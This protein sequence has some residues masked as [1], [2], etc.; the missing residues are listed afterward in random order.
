M[1][2]INRPN[3]EIEIPAT[4]LRL[5]S[6]FKLTYPKIKPSKLVTPPQR[7][8]IAAHK[9]TNPNAGEAIAKNLAFRNS[10]SRLLGS[11]S[12]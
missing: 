9:L 6:V 1:I 8:I 12:I 5:C 7:G 10:G 4:A 11:L 2:V 3:K